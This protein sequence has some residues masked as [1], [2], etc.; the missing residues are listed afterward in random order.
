MAK[1]PRIRITLDPNTKAKLELEA[2]NQN[3]H[4]TDLILEAIDHWFKCDRGEGIATMKLILL[5]YPATCKKCDKKLDAGQWALWGKGFGAICLD[6]Y[7]R[8][9][10]DKTLITKELKVRQLKHMK[11][12]LETEI[13]GLFSKY[14]D[15]SAFQEIDQT[16]KLISELHSIIMNYLKAGI[17]SQEEMKVLEEVLTFISDAKVRLA[18]IADW[19]MKPKKKKKKLKYE[20]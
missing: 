19:L 11:K 20:V 12:A 10:G 5:R 18:D 4:I 8:R 2:Q 16:G 1:D 14:T 17:A 3:K 13:E 6:C 9:I 15:F 7:I